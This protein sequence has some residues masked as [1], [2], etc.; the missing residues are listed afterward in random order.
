MFQG[1]GSER[2]GSGENCHPSYLIDSEMAGPIKLK[3]GRMV[4]GMWENNLV[5]EF[6]RSINIDR[7]QVSGPLVPLL[8]CGND[9]EDTT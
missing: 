9:K 1:E 7:G 6:F 4:E 2:S 3:L 8:G 5:K